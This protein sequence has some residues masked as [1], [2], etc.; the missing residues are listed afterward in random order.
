MRSISADPLARAAAWTPLAIVIYFALQLALRLWLSTNLE[1]DDAEMVGQTAWAWGYANSHPPLFHWIVRLCYDAF[2]NWPAATAVPKFAL[3]ALGYFFVYDAA[4]RAGGSS[5][6]GAIAVATLFFIP[7][8]AWKT[9]SKLT[10]SILGF[11]ATAATLQALV[12]VLTRRAWWIF[13]WLGLAAAVGLLAKYNFV[14]VLAA[15]LVAIGF[16][17]EA[18]RA[19]LRPAAFL[20]PLVFLVLVAPHLFWI[21]NH[22]EMAA[23]RAYILRTGGGPLGLSLS[24]GSVVDGLVSLTLVVLVSVAPALVIFLIAKRIAHPSF[25][26]ENALCRVVGVWLLAELAILIAIVIAGGIY[27]VHERYILVLLPPVALWFALRFRLSEQP[28]AVVLICGL[29]VFLAF[30]I[31]IARP[32]SVMRGN[33]RLAW[34]YAEMAEQIRELTP[35]SVAIL[36][37]RPENAANIAIRLTNASIFDAHGTQ[38][39]VLLLADN[40]EALQTARAKLGDGYGPASDLRVITQP[41]RWQPE[42]QASLA[43]QLWKRRN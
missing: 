35:G 33:G 14:V 23:E 21:R 4:R 11:A 39:P 28:R 12:L 37:D 22:P 25:V 8:V 26:R 43:A 10:H 29:A 20:A 32:L 19:M 31:T 16:V 34:P 9:E 6:V 18:R 7:V 1:V 5:V 42:R 2:G 41:L 40:P 27:Q 24:A 15:G 36:A 30:V 17:P 38:T 13:A 3:L